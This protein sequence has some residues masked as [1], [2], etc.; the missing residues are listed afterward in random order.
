MDK[1]G[2]YAIFLLC[3]FLSL[4]FTTVGYEEGQQKNLE[5]QK[6]KPSFMERLRSVNSI[7][8]SI[9]GTS[10]RQRNGFKT[11]ISQAHAYFFPPSIDFR[12]EHEAQPSIDGGAGEKAKEAIAKSTGKT[13]GTLEDSAKSAAKVASEMVQKTK[14]KLKK[15]LSSETGT[16]PKNEL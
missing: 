15:S 6:R 7:I 8:P 9:S 3:L 12:G 10:T 2:G 13:K 1:V 14:E 11:L 16:E 5:D 4:P